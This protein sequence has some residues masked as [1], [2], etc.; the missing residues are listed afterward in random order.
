M[1]KIKQLSFL[2]EEPKKEQKKFFDETLEFIK[3]MQEESDY[4]EQIKEEFLYYLDLGLNE[5]ELKNF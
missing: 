5:E 2:K 3:K 1:E 4:L